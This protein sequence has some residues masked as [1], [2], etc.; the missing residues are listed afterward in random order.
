MDTIYS[1][2]IFTLTHK[3]THLNDIG[4]FVLSENDSDAALKERLLEIKKLMGMRELMYL[5]TC[6]RITFFFTSDD[7]ADGQFYPSKFIATVYGHLSAEVLQKAND[8]ALIFEGREAISH[9][10]EVAASMDSMVVGEREILRQLRETYEKNNEMGLTG[11]AIRLA[12]RFCVEAAKKVYSSTKIGEKPVS[13]VSLSIQ[14]MLEK[15]LPSDAR[16]LLIGAGQTNRLVIK[17][18]QKH[19]YKNITV[20]NRSLKSAEKLASILGGEAYT[21]DALSSYNKGFDV[22]FAATAATEV[23][24]TKEIYNSMDKADGNKKL[25]IDLSIPA[26]I[27]S[28]IA[29]EF[30]ADYISMD[31]LKMIAQ[32]N[33]GFREQELGKAQEIVDE[34]VDTFHTAFKERQIEL[35]MRE[36]PE[37]I[38]AIRAHALNNVFKNEISEL[39]EPQREL[40]DRVL[41]YMEKRCIAIPIQVAKEKLAHS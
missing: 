22:I 14:K 6:N 12:M 27:D 5:A 4:H 23:I 31:D 34:Y 18:L 28:S 11:D 1:Y 24:L 19:G 2:K 30:D 20:F 21:I 10:F 35:A 13:V 39:D 32:E 29:Q 8:N 41:A 16:F 3:N 9:L 17:F 37:Q 15:Q 38:K 26:N 25:L 7:N 36:V 33:I 40:F